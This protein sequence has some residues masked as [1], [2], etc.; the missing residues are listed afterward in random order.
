MLTNRAVTLCVIYL[1]LMSKLF[2]EEDRNQDFWCAC[3]QVRAESRCTSIA[4]I[5]AKAIYKP[6]KS[7]YLQPQVIVRII[8]CQG[9]KLP[10]NTLSRELHLE[11]LNRAEQIMRSEQLNLTQTAQIISD[12]PAP[13]F[14]ISEATACG[15]YYKLLK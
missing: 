3:E 15:L 10:K 9:K 6:A 11:I 8:R 5:A 12:Q 7:F 1:I 14:Y 2:Y 4:D 13:R